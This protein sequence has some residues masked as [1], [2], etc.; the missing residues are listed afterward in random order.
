MNKFALIIG[1][2]YSGSWKVYQSYNDS[3][4]FHN[5]LTN[6]YNI[7][8][9]NILTLYN[10][11]CTQSN[12][13]NYLKKFVRLLGKDSVGIIYFAGHGT[14]TRDQNGDEVDGMDENYQTYDRKLISDDLITNFLENT[15]P[16][17]TITLI[18]DHCHSGS[19]IDF[20]EKHKNRKWISIGSAKDYESAI[21]SG[22]GSVC[23]FELFN[24]IKDKPL[25]K[26]SEIRDK[27]IENMGN[28]FIGLMQNPVISVSHNKLFDKYLFE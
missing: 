13:I 27:L 1:C 5:I 24:I 8:E 20:K 9:N 4:K 14:Q 16:S 2:D 10:N 28:S 23:S 25:I 7:P 17:V 12:I 3:K 6:I 18:S 19:M 11:E 26:Y 21:Q 22:D 15:D